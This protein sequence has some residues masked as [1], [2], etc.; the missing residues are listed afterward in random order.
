MP[1]DQSMDPSASVRLR[2]QVCASLNLYGHHMHKHRSSC[3]RLSICIFYCWASPA[4]P[5]PDTSVPTA[6]G[7]THLTR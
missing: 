4:S 2:L 5:N 7:Q 3:S 1:R 6:D